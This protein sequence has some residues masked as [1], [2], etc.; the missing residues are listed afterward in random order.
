MMSNCWLGR[1]NFYD[2]STGCWRS[3]SETDRGHSPRI[4]GRPAAHPMRGTDKGTG[5]TFKVTHGCSLPSSPGFK[6]YSTWRGMMDRCYN[7]NS[8]D[9]CRYGARGIIV[10]KSWMKFAS[11]LADMGIRK[12]GLSIGRID[13]NKGYS[14]TNC[15]WETPKQQGRNRRTNTFLM[16]K[17]KTRAIAECAEILGIGRDRIYQRLGAGWPVEKALTS[18]IY[19]DRRQ[20]GK[21]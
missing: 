8:K 20:Y 3:P 17:G 5:M 19:Y 2:H 21:R 4:C 1:S 11:F 7:K 16:F 10:C 12:S 18:T 13:N 14:P 6:T 9:Y 15:R